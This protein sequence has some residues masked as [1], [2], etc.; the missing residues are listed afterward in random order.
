MK[1]NSIQP[2]GIYLKHHLKA[3]TENILFSERQKSSCLIC[4]YS[5]FLQVATNT[6]TSKNVGHAILYEIVLTIMGIKSEAGLRVCTLPRGYKT[7]LML[8]CV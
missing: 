2:T 7:F 4:A 1:V 3:C 5:I 6:D 8:N